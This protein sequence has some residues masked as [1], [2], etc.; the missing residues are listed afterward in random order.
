MHVLIYYLYTC[1][2]TQQHGSQL[3]HEVCGLEMIIYH[4]FAM[5]WH[6]LL[7]H[8]IKS[9]GCMMK[10]E[11][12][13]RPYHFTSCSEEGPIIIVG[14]RDRTYYVVTITLR[15]R[16]TGIYVYQFYSRIV[17]S[18][19][20]FVERSVDHRGIYDLWCTVK[21]TFFVWDKMQIYIPF[22]CNVS[23]LVVV[24]LQV[25]SLLFLELVTVWCLSIK[26]K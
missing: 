8:G 6:V 22:S 25:V 23:V 26:I 9:T 14:H 17:W 13:I 3:Y 15:L 10:K 24:G 12:L 11:K 19:L 18:T 5:T 2:S 16:S 21:R 20:I 1:G 4:N 7:V